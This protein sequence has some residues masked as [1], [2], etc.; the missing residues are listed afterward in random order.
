MNI[1]LVDE[2]EFRKDKSVKISRKEYNEL[3]NE[4][5]E[6][7]DSFIEFN[8]IETFDTDTVITDSVNDKV[9]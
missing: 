7:T 1:C 5:T 6:F 2:E 3:M 9:I 8:G 4:L